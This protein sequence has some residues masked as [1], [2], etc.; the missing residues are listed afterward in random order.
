MN[1]RIGI[2]DLFLRQHNLLID[3]HLLLNNA[4]RLLLIGS[5]LRFRVRDLLLNPF[6]FFLQGLNICHDFIGSGG[7][8]RYRKGADQQRQNHQKHQNQCQY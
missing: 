2:L 1:L 7:G 8:S 6:R 4:K 5:Q 3:L